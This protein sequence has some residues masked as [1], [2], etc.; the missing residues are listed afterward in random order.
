MTTIETWKEFRGTGY[1]VSNLGRVKGKS[2]NLLTP[3]KNNKGYMRVRMYYDGERHTCFIHRLM[4]KTFK[5]PIPFGY[6]IDHINNDKE[7]NRMDNYQLLTKSENIAKRWER[8]RRQ[9]A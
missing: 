8:Y 5:G 9:A 2:D 4:W 7:D 3:D 6:E 1:K